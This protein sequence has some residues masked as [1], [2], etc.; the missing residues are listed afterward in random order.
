MTLS[1]LPSSH[2]TLSGTYDVRHEASYPTDRSLL[3]ETRT[4]TQTWGRKWAEQKGRICS[5]F[6]VRCLY[7]NVVE[8][9]RKNSLSFVSFTRFILFNNFHYSLGHFS[10]LWF[11]SL[12]L[13][14]PLLLYF[15]V[16]HIT[17]RGAVPVPSLPGLAFAVCTAALPL[18]QLRDP[19]IATI[20]LEA[21]KAALPLVSEPSPSSCYSSP[22]Q[23]K[24][25]TI[26]VDRIQHLLDRTEQI[27]TFFPLDTSYLSHIS[28]LSPAFEYYSIQAP[29]P[30]KFL[31]KVDR[32]TELFE[33]E[34][35]LALGSLRDTAFNA[36]F[37]KIVVQIL[38]IVPPN[39]VVFTDTKELLKCHANGT[40][41]T[42]NS[43]A[44]FFLLTKSSTTS[45]RWS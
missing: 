10:L 44:G 9:G 8:L 2:Q 5:G 40:S 25:S 13:S 28:S 23:S 17:Y 6:E 36:T 34:E 24:S 43:M 14:L 29:A 19:D 42:T 18:L 16:W 45:P 20:L 37:I 38:A 1:L 41:D 31:K 4:W 30:S 3:R 11:L 15:I 22:T 26:D 21:L 27:L 39:Y 12:S 35:S 7:L 33:G 32:V